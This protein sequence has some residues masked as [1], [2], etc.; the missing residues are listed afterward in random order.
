MEP[1]AYI[2]AVD[3]ALLPLANDDHAKVMSAYLKGQFPF[4]GIPAPKRRQAVKLIGI[5]KWDSSKLFEVVDLL[6]Q[7]P[8][9]EYRYTA[10]DLL[11]RHARVIQ[12]TKLPHLHRLILTDSWWETVDGLAGV[13]S[14]MFHP[15]YNTDGHYAKVAMD[16]W[17]AHNNFWSQRVAML[18]QL[19]WRMHTNSDRLFSYAKLL[20]HEKEFFL[21]KAIGWALRD[22][23]RWNP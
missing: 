22:Y 19:G 8:E 15:C 9:R 23:A 18:H 21:R 1:K 16:E 5:N 2:A 10:I 14:A 17:I 20:A 4:L 6:W 11:R 7:R 13:V 12:V 3:T